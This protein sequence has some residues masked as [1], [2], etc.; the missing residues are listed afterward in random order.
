[1][2]SR[3][4]SPRSRDSCSRERRLPCTVARDDGAVVLEFF[5][6]LDVVTSVGFERRLRDALASGAHYVVVD[7]SGLDFI[8]CSGVRALVSVAADAPGDRLAV[9][10]GPES[11]DRVFRLTE[12]EH[13]LPFAD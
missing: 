10:R 5:G 4:R 12:T 2:T 3:T 13:R 1:M 9:L 11:V 8:D 7:L 6:D